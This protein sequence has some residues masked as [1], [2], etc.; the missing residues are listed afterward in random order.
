MRASTVALLLLGPGLLLRV[1]EG[2]AESVTLKPTSI[3]LTKEEP[4][5][6][7]SVTNPGTGT[8]RYQLS[9]SAWSQ[10]EAGKMV[11]HDTKEVVFFPAF[12][13]LPP[14]A[15][16][17]VRIGAST[18][19]GASERTFRVTLDELPPLETEAKPAGVAVLTRFSVPVFLEPEK[20]E[21]KPALEANAGKGTV[22][23]TLKNDGNAHLKPTAVRVRFLAADGKLVR[24]RALDAWYVLAG[25]RRRWEVTPT[26]EE[27][28]GAARA[29]VSGEI[30]RGV[31]PVTAAVEL[32]SVCPRAR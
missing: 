17:K 19:F 12:V 31:D 6:L 1:A 23:I 16:K 28:A 18:P 11:L 3:R 8:K 20:P 7:L 9:A 27:C 21:P 25:G 30:G 26:P 10:D 13:V 15:E 32:G 14:G 5:A 4:S 24:E 29:E 22:R 2:R